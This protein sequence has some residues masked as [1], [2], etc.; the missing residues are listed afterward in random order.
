[1]DGKVDRLPFGRGSMLLDPCTMQPMDAL[2]LQESIR[3]LSDHAAQHSVES[4][5]ILQWDRANR[6]GIGKPSD[7]WKDRVR[8]LRLEGLYSEVSTYQAINDLMW[9]MRVKRKLTEHDAIEEIWRWLLDNHNECSQS[10]N[11]GKMSAVRKKIERIGAAFDVTKVTPLRCEWTRTNDQQHLTETD[12]IELLRYPLHGLKELLAAWSLLHYCK[13]RMSRR[14]NKK[15][16]PYVPQL[17]QDFGAL[18][19]VPQKALNQSVPI[20]VTV[21]RTLPGFPKRNTRL[22]RLRL[23]GA[24]LLE[25]R[26]GYHVDSGTCADYWLRFQ[27]G[28]ESSSSVDCI[29]CALARLVPKQGLMNRF[30]DSATKRILS[31]QCTSAIQDCKRIV[32]I[33]RIV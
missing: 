15:G 27:F 25:P 21:E 6:R 7:C 32:R 9:D 29:Y 11:A 22:M 26:K 5:T 28:P 17:E 16:N 18:T 1:M 23:M 4:E 12:L 2:S 10:I 3:V 14:G 20:P 13:Q 8:R 30:G 31:C 33:P 24:G 19:H